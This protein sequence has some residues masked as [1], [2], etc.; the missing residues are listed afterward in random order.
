MVRTSPTARLALIAGS[1]LVTLLLLELGCRLARGPQ[2]LLDWQNLV[3]KERLGADG[4][5]AERRFVYDAMLG[6]LQRP[7]FASGSMH[8]DADGFRRMPPAPGDAAAPPILATGDSYTQGDE[9]DDA[10]TWPAQ[11]QGMVGRRTVNAGVAAYGLDQTVLRTELLVPRLKPALAIVGFIADDLRRAEMKRTWGTEKPYFEPDG[12]EL[13]LRNVPVPP[14]PDPR[15]TLSV[16]QTAFGWSI[17]VDTVLKHQGWQYEWAIDHQRV[18]PRGTGERMACPMMR[19]LARLGVP[20]LV[21]AQYDFYVWVNAEFGAEQRRL[22]KA[23]L[24]CADHAGLGSLDLYDATER[25]VRAQGRD[26]VYLTWH[27]S[28]AGYRLIA[29]EIAAEIRRRG[30]MPAR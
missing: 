13:K 1:V 8:Y 15:D 6:Y 27:P 20:I 14:S 18:L 21:V 2:A 23:V 30:Y 22:S 16:L 19:R 24:E 11:L 28:P 7:N 29:I 12:D 9:V 5:R 10:A 3:L 4:V 26:A 17:L 25:A